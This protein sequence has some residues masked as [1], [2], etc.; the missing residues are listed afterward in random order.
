M[1][2]SLRP[3]S[4]D[5]VYHALNRAN[6]RRTLF[7]DDGD[8]A[9][10][11]RVLGQACERVTMRLLAYCVI[12][13]HRH[14]VVWPRKDGDMS[15]FMNWLTL[16]HTQRWHQHRHAVGEGACVPRALHIVSCRNE[17]VSPDGLS[18]RRAES[19]ASGPRRTSGA[20]VLESCWDSR[21]CPVAGVAD[22]AF[23]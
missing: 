1:G 2:R 9:A 19:S 5:V 8:Y 7:E 6:A 21:L 18:L 15:R 23:R 20:V 3:T 16:P 10:C 22:G 17:R 14:L 11:A 4:T 12:P 13:N